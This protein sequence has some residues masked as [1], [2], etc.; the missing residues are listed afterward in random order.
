MGRVPVDRWYRCSDLLRVVRGE[1]QAPP[2]DDTLGITI[3]DVQPRRITAEWRADPRLLNGHGVVMGGFISA[4]ADIAMAY[5]MASCLTDDRSF[6]SITLQTTFHRP[7][8]PGK[9]DI[10]A[11]VERLGRTVAYLSADIYQNER[12]VATATSSV[13]IRGN[14]EG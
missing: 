7:A 2:C 4:A 10:V 8:V 5:A 6:A 1:L 3:T 14:E 13:L 11:K 9:L 12:H